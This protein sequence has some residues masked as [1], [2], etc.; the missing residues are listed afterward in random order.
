M[1]VSGR[2]GDTV[3]LSCDTIVVNQSVCS[4]ERVKG[5]TNEL[6]YKKYAGEIVQEREGKAEIKKEVLEREKGK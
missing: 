4:Q 1:A 3:L 6:V 2:F 5:L